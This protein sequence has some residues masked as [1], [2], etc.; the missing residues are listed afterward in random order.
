MATRS[1]TTRRSD[2]VPRGVVCSFAGWTGDES[3][4]A[5]EELGVCLCDAS[6]ERRVGG[7][8]GQPPTEPCLP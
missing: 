2:G 8:E 1:P 7:G 4:R 6:D 3:G 5:P